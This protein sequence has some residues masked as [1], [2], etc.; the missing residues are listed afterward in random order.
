MNGFNFHNRFGASTEKNNDETA[1]VHPPPTKDSMPD[2]SFQDFKGLG[3]SSELFTK[4]KYQ[5]TSSAASYTS[6]GPQNEP[7]A[8]DSHASP[9]MREQQ[10]PDSPSKPSHPFPTFQ[11]NTLRKTSL[12]KPPSLSSEHRE[13]GSPEKREKAAVGPLGQ[14]IHQMNLNGKGGRIPEPGMYA[15]IPHVH[16]DE[17]QTRSRPNSFYGMERPAIADNDSADGQASHAQEPGADAKDDRITQAD[18]TESITTGARPSSFFGMGQASGHIPNPDRPADLP[19]QAARFAAAHRGDGN[20][21]SDNRSSPVSLA[22]SQSAS[23]YGSQGTNGATRPASIAPTTSNALL[24][25]S[26][27]R[28]GEQAALLS[29][30]KTLELYRQN[31]KKTNDPDLIYEF[32]VFMIDAA[33]SM[34]GDDSSGGSG[35]AGS[36]SSVGHQNKEETARDELIKEAITLLRRVAE[37]GHMDAQYFL[38]DCYAN[39]IGTSKSKPDYDRAYPLFV[40]AAKHGHSDAAYRA[41]MSYEKGWGCRRDSSKAVQFY[42]KAASMSHPGALYRLGTAELNGD[43]GLKKSAREGVKWLK[44]S[45]EA[46]TP[47][48]PH[49]LHELALLHER[50]VDNVIYADPDYACELLAQAGEM[51]YAPSAYKLGVNYEYGRMGCP[52]DAGLS[53]H[54][55]N[56]AAQQNHREACFALTAW[57]LV[58]APGIL[59]Q[60]DTEAYLWAKKAAEQGLAKAEYA[61]GYFTESGIGT[62]RDMAEAKAWYSRAADHGEK[63]AQQRVLSMGGPASSANEK[64]IISSVIQEGRRGSDPKTGAASISQNPGSAREQGLKI[65]AA[66]AARLQSMQRVQPSNAPF[67]SAVGLSAMSPTNGASYPTPLTMREVQTANREHAHHLAVQHHQQMQMKNGNN[68]NEG[69]PNPYNSPPGSQAS[70]VYTASPPSSYAQ[71]SP[72]GAPVP[73]GHSPHYPPSH[74]GQPHPNQAHWRPRPPMPAQRQPSGS[75]SAYAP[76]GAHSNASHTSFPVHRSPPIRQ[77]SVPTDPAQGQTPY[78]SYPRQGQHDSNTIPVFRQADQSEVTSTPPEKKKGLWAQLK[79]M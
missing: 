31:A 19:S 69:L 52:Q 10:P 29:H 6:H 44:R 38:G 77:M 23:N 39:G 2:F 78:P 12:P 58:G 59:P 34:G 27:L 55:Y 65:A 67:P 28:P 5:P 7:V 22:P 3:E 4:Y 37:R 47:E 17:T 62:V 49:A 30:N 41:G 73:L 74:L 11:S 33:K 14:A 24:D 26:H 57:Y 42:R 60:S 54:M 8:S 56:I 9:R 75:D 61:V 46:A 72:Q 45:S 16:H 70:H 32:A 1:K 21:S 71:F 25:H 48:F 51:G 35:P 64:N 20:D 68:P 43:L 79:S 53:I 50:G 13:Q 66:E 15:N 40:L 18:A 36:G 63:R 76:S